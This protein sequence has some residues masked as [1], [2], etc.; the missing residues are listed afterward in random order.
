[1]AGKPRP[2]PH[3][4]APMRSLL[5]ELIHL[6]LQWPLWAVLGL[7]AGAWRLRAVP[8]WPRR[9]IAAALLIH[10]VSMPATSQWLLAGIEARHPPRTPQDLLASLPSP[11][12]DGPVLLVLSAGWIRHAETGPVI[13]MGAASWE[14]TAAAVALWRETGGRL[15]FSGAPLPDG[16]DSVADRM[17]AAAR[18]MGVPAERIGIERRSLNTHENLRLSVDG[19]G[20]AGRRDVVLVT[21]ALHMGRAV[22]AAH[23]VGLA[24]QPYPCDHTTDRT[25]HWR[26]WLPD[27][28]G[29]GDLEQGL[30]EWLGLLRYHWKG[31]A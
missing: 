26:H 15:I 5:T 13:V 16:T 30:H 22:A 29:P 2:P 7:L 8:R 9:L 6:A 18:G 25:R 20:L 10:M 23:G 11:S 17:A 19:F 21:S 14:R 24:V 28:D 12:S 3:T 4:P 31:W 1:M 27:N